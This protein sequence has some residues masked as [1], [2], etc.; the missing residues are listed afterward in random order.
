METFFKFETGDYWV[1]LT[2]EEIKAFA[3]GESISGK[4]LRR[5]NEMT[6]ELKITIR[7]APQKVIRRF[8]KFLRSR[9][10]YFFE[11]QSVMGVRDNEHHRFFYMKEDIFDLHT[12]IGSAFPAGYQENRYCSSTGNKI[13]LFHKEKN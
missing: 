10:I 4:L 9:N 5:R 2:D 6:E 11:H 7:S 13:F 3:L 1:Y 12:K 8:K